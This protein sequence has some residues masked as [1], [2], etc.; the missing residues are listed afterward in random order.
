MKNKNQHVIPNCYLKSWCDPR[1]PAEKIPYI[2]RISKDGTQKKN[3][4]PEKS[5]TANNRYTITMPNGNRNLV[6]ENTLGGIENQF[7]NVLGRIRRREDLTPRDRAHV[8]LFTACKL[9]ELELAITRSN[10]L[11]RVVTRELNEL[12]TEFDL[13]N[14]VMCRSC[15]CQQS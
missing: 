10:E 12:L 5:F 8:C 14:P 11:Q 13:A 1:T 6:I 7:V 15:N 4:S 2:W 3:K 9:S